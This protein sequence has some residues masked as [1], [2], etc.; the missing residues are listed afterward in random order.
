[1]QWRKGGVTAALLRC[2]GDVKGEVSAWVR[3]G[4]G[5]IVCSGVHTA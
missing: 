1:M 3:E 5:W 2:V 4:G